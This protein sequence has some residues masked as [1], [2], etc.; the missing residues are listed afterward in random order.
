MHQYQQYP[1]RVLNPLA[2]I[3]TQGNSQEG[4]VRRHKSLKRDEDNNTGDN[5]INGRS[6]GYS[7]GETVKRK[8]STRGLSRNGTLRHRDDQQQ[9][10]EINDNN[11]NIE[12]NNGNNTLIHIDP[13]VQFSKGSL[14]EKA[15]S[16]PSSTSSSSNNNN[17]SGNG[18]G[19]LTRSKSTRDY[20]SSSNHR[21]RGDDT[22]ISH[23]TSIRRKERSKPKDHH[24]VPLPN[25]TAIMTSTSSNPVSTTSKSHSNNNTLLQL[26]N[27]PERFH[28]QTL[29]QR[30]MKPLINFDKD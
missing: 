16:I 25:T 23:H 26:N 24:D 17:N 2:A 4:G 12:D 1:K 5:N 20:S 19:G 18:G 15:E 6:R 14:L 29:L 3:T 21:S 11:N 28:T 30:Q 10:N 27:T 8:A 13:K 7:Q 22:V 9:P